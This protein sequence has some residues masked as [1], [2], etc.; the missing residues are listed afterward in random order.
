MILLAPAGCQSL[1]ALG[2]VV[3]IEKVVP[4]EGYTKDNIIKFKKEQRELFIRYGVT[5]AVVSL[6]Y[7]LG[8]H[9]ITQASIDNKFYKTVGSIA[10]STSAYFTKYLKESQ[11]QVKEFHGKTIPLTELYESFAVKAFH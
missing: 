8:I 11:V 4:P 2:Q 6:V 5:D 7:W 1:S 10:R 3:G 9:V